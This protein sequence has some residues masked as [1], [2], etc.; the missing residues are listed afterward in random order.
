MNYYQTELFGVGFLTVLN[1]S[2]TRECQ[3][4]IDLAALTM[5]ICQERE[6]TLW[7]VFIEIPDRV[8]PGYN[9]V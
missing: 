8:D 1:C 6:L 3:H 2:V 9:L 5:L 4:R 7:E